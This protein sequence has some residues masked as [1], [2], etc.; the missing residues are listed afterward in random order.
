MLLT[1]AQ[2][3]REQTLSQP[4]LNDILNFAETV[5]HRKSGKHLND[6]QRVVLYESLLATKKTYEQ[7]ANEHGYSENYIQQVVA[8]KLWKLLTEGIGEKVTKANV[9]SVLERNLSQSSPQHLSKNREFQP[10]HQPVKSEESTPQ[11]KRLLILYPDG[12]TVVTLVQ[13]LESA[14]SN[15]ELS[16]K[17]WQNLFEKAQDSQQK[18]TINDYDYCL[19]LLEGTC[20]VD[21][22]I[23]DQS[24]IEVIQWAITCKG[25]P[26]KPP[27]IVIRISAFPLFPLTPMNEQF[28]HHSL[29]IPQLLWSSSSDTAKLLKDISR[30]LEMNPELTQNLSGF[31]PWM[32][33]ELSE[34]SV[35]LN[36]RF[37]VERHPDELRCYQEIT[38]PG[39]MVSLKAPKQMGKTSLLNRILAYAASRNYQTVLIDFQK[40]DAEI[41][42]DSN[43]LLRWLCANI[44]RQFEFEVK[45]DDY[46]D[47]DLGSKMSCSLFFQ[48]YLLKQVQTPLV[49]ALEEVNE[50]FENLSSARTLLTLLR[51]WH[52]ES[53]FSCIWQKLRLVLVQST[54]VYVPLNINQSPFYGGLVIDL[55]PFNVQ[56]VQQLAKAYELTLSVT[57]CDRLMALLGG[58]PYLVRLTLEHIARKKSSLQELIQSADTDTSIYIEHLHRLLGQLQ[59]HSELQRAFAQV[60]SSSE[61]VMLEPSQKFKLKSMG[62]VRLHNNEVSVSCQLYQRYFKERLH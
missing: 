40:A 62:L 7:I 36:S 52:E 41:L 60:L 56:Q 51:S 35:A 43:K 53:K 13:T 42:S 49:L 44:C 3:F 18:A 6:L 32:E 5:I 17:S 20:P 27:L 2:S 59:Q 4:H 33:A 16:L 55:R 14:L 58:H 12:E 38:K 39:A 37:Y 29:Q 47:S 30:H 9:R 54:E 28:K 24:M 26:Q 50:V 22:S 11:K 10:P 61:S 34:G 31:C 25:N 48:E 45:L 21:Q 46:W 8:T 15:Y 57:E 19:L 1:A 23:V